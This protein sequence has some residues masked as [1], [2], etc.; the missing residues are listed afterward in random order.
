MTTDGA[1]FAIGQ[2]VTQIGKSGHVL[3]DYL[4][5]ISPTLAVQFSWN[6][7]MAA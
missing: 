5:I 6:G 7:S 1:P 3:E 4:K 2:P